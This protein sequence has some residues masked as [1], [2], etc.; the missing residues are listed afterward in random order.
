[1]FN[2]EHREYLLLLLVIPVLMILYVLYLLRRRNNIRRIGDPEIIATLMPDYSQFR[3]NLK[4]FLLLLTVALI[5]V[6]IAGPRFGSRLTQV[7]HEGIDI[8]IALD[9]SNSMLAEDIKPNR[10]ERAKQ[11]LSRLLDRLENDRV[12]LIVFAGNAYTQIP[13]TNDYL[14]AK[15]FLSNI[16]TEM[17][18]RQG[19]AIG[20]AIEL[21]LRS[22]NP[23]SK[24]GK[25][26]L[27]ISDGENHEGDVE[28][29]CKNAS[30]KG[31]RIYTIGMGLTQGVRIPAAGNNLYVK[32]YRRDREGNFVITRLNEQM[33]KD[34]ADAGNGRYYR[35]SSPD[36]GL[37]SMMVELNKLDK[38]SSEA[39]EYSEYE[40]QFPGVIWIALFF[41]ILEF[42]LLERKNK[43]LRNIKVFD[44]LKS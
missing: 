20:D 11:E 28:K 15:M 34:I 40:E 29:A 10:L 31:V 32:D 3:N 25:A 7:K 39:T 42:L 35:A 33:L 26:I 21:G 43:W 12:G 37:N 4:F 1:M 22:F 5:I 8:I 9:V 30:E 6:A 27:I 41:L 24:A 17:V 2:F 36:M 14:S 38:E 13:I 16:N 18:S 23:Q 44:N 19:T